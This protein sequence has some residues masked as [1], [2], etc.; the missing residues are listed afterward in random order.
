M[1]LHAIASEIMRLTFTVYKLA[2]PAKPIKLRIVDAH[3]ILREGSRL[4]GADY[5][6]GAHR[7]TGMHLAHKIIARQHTPHT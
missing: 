4:V 5:C 6:S 2:A 1:E 3:T 7:F